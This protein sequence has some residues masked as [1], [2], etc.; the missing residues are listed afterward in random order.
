MESGRL[1]VVGVEEPL[2]VTKSISKK[3]SSLTPDAWSRTLRNAPLVERSQI[4]LSLLVSN[5]SSTRSKAS[6]PMR[7]RRRGAPWPL[8]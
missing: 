5:L 6:V 8:W 4:S 3:S 1:P 2:P 7:H